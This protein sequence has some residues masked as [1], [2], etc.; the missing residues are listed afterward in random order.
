M[1]IKVGVLATVCNEK[2][3]NL[4]KFLYCV[5]VFCR[6]TFLYIVNTHTHIRG[7][8]LSILYKYKNRTKYEGRR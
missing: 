8:Y 2:L 1:I 6:A 3:T 5:Y 7:M 4:F